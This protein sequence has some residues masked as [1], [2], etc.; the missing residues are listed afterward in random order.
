MGSVTNLITDMQVKGAR[1]DHVVRAVKHSM[2]VIDAEKHDLDYRQS[3]VDNGIRQL[4][5]MYQGGERKGASTL[6]SQATAKVRIDARK[7]RLAQHGGPIDPLTGERKYEPKG[8]TRNK[9]DKKTGTYDKDVKVP[10][11]E[12]VKRLALTSDAHT[13]VSKHASPVELIYADHA[14]AMKALANSTRLSAYKIPTPHVNTAAKKVYKVEVD[15]L[16]R[17]LREAQA[18]APLDRQAQRIAN[19]NIKLRLQDDPSLR[20]DADRR[21]KVERQAKEAARNKLGLKKYEMDITDREWDAIQ[22][23]AVS[24]NIFRGILDGNHVKPARLFEL[25]LPKTNVVLSGPVLSRAK[26]MLATGMTNADIAKHLGISPS[27]L[28]AAFTTKDGD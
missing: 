12:N 14:N 27:T 24:A 21:K 5:K 22:A 4:K 8:I 20:Y 7:P 18:K 1:A 11:T 9:F 25:A 6:L 13:L 2:V 23:G 28:R 3:E 15:N 16:V 17:Q 26:A 19:A 10:T